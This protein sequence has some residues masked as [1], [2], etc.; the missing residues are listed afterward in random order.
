MRK[1]FNNEVK[2]VNYLDK[3]DV[4][5]EHSLSMLWRGINLRTLRQVADLLGKGQGADKRMNNWM[6]FCMVSQK[7]EQDLG[8]DK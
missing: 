6:V 3:L 4:D 1:S 8:T 2:P 5:N 7:Q